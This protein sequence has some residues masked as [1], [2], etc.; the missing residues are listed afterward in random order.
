[1]LVQQPSLLEGSR[2]LVQ[3][4]GTTSPGRLTSAAYLKKRGTPEASP[5]HGQPRVTKDLEFSTKSRD[6]IS[7]A[8]V[9]PIAI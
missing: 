1:M 6:E 9:E 5:A 8:V 7:L 2:T 3:A 4:L